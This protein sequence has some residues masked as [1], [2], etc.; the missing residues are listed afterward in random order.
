MGCK[1]VRFGGQKESFWK[2]K[3]V[4]LEGKRSRFGRQKESFWKEAPPKNPQS[5]TPAPPQQGGEWYDLRGYEG[6]GWDNLTGDRQTVGGYG[7]LAIT[8]YSLSKAALQ[9]VQSRPTVLSIA[10][11]QF[12]Q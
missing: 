1:R 4:V 6:D 7:V 8:S 2:V 11:L 9:F 3:G 12:C 5:P 10:T